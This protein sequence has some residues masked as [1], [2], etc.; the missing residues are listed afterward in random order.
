VKD[1]SGYILTWIQK[2]IKMS[3][4]VLNKYATIGYNNYIKIISK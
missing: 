4:K 3:P 1:E 2:V